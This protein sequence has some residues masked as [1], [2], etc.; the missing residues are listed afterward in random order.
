MTS[1]MA[2]RSSKKRPAKGSTKASRR[3]LR[4]ER[5]KRKSLARPSTNPSRDELALME[6]IADL[7]VHEYTGY[8]SLALPK[9]IWATTDDLEAGRSNQQY[10]VFRNVTKDDLISIQNRRQKHGIITKATI[11]KCIRMSHYHDTKLLVIKVTPQTKHIVPPDTFGTCLRQELR[12][13]GM[14]LHALIGFGKTSFSNAHASKEGDVT[15][16]RSLRVARW[17]TLAI[18]S[19]FTELMTRLR[20]DAHWWLLN[21]DSEVKISILI[22][23]VAAEE[24]V[25]IEKWCGFLPIVHKL[26]TRV[27]PN[28]H[29]LLLKRMQH[30]TIVK[31]SASA[32]GSPSFTVTGAPLVLEFERLF[33]RAPV[34]PEGDVVLTGENL[35]DWAEHCVFQCLYE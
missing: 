15:L 11:S 17:P 34:S 28:A 4:V 30:V 26:V 14:G 12:K 35:S 32:S 21:S 8:R 18:E 7:P 9:Q 1:N 2:P 20:Y 31:S 19:G 25:Y 6:G 24:T 22:A 5:A 3:A 33:L 16:G 13:M 27:H 23:I 29:S 10:V